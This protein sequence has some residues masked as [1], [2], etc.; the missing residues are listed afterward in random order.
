MDRPIARRTVIAGAG[1]GVV[2]LAAHAHAE[3]KPDIQAS[4]FSAKPSL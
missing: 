3:T 1:A 2:S 4:E